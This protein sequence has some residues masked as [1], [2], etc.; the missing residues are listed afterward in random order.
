MRDDLVIVEDDREAGESLQRALRPELEGVRISL[1]ATVDA[2]QKLFQ[3]KQPGVVV[4]DLHLDE[5]SGIESGL[6][7]LSEFSARGARV[8]VLTGHNSQSVGVRSIQAG[9][10]SF[11]SKPP[12]IPHLA[13]LIQDGFRQAA[14][15]RALQNAEKQFQDDLVERRLIGVSPSIQHVRQELLFAAHTG[16]PLF[17]HGETGTGKGLCAKLVHELS[18]QRNAPFVRFQPIVEGADLVGSELFGH[19]KG[20]FTGADQERI[21]LVES[22]SKGTLFLDEVDELPKS[23]QV[24]LL[25]LL[26]DGN[27]RRLGES[28]ERTA[29]FRLISASNGEVSELLDS[30]K[31]RSD[32]F[33]RISHLQLSL[34]PLRS[35]KEDIEPLAR[36]ILEREPL[37]HGLALEQQTIALLQDHQWPG[38][39]R[40]L[41]AAVERAGHRAKFRGGSEILPEDCRL[42]GVSGSSSAEAQTFHEKVDVF[43]LEL[44]QKALAENGGNQ[45]RAARQLGLDRS[46]IR[47][48][49]EK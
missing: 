38:N 19:V 30:G 46:T 45:V 17:I 44:V 10:S 39:V 47:R 34:P 42:H 6:S 41:E 14:L 12:D 27:F 11:L 18:A 48:I 7:L 8:I 25:G 21:G 3:E 35:R 31:L 28:R 4:L 23:V 1:A 9:A 20:A 32:L 5:S 49:L 13:A 37:F 15:Q 26:Q 33:H 16:Q 24:A 36:S 40:E 22:A 43:R 29:E 2:A